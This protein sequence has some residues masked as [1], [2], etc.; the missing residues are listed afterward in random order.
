MITRIAT[1]YPLR[2]DVYQVAFALAGRNGKV[3]STKDFATATQANRAKQYYET[4]GLDGMVE[5]ALAAADYENLINT[6]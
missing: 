2:H 1:I 4:H 6:N 3:V 5:Y